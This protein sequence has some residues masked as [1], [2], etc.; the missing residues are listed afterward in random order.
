MLFTHA[1]NRFILLSPM[2]E[3]AATVGSE[4]GAFF[5]QATGKPPYPCQ[6]RLATA[7]RFPQLLDIPT[8][9]GKTADKE[10]RRQTSCRLVYRLPTRTLVA[11]IN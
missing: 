1:G 5:K 2:R 11:S 8:G 7:N 3:A 9:L 10:T 4:F 6:I